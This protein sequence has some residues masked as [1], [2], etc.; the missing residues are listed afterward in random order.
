MLSTMNLEIASYVAVPM[1][2]YNNI[3]YLDI[4]FIKI[5]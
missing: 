3:T 4:L 1:S 5:R 2:N